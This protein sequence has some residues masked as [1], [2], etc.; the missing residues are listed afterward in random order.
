MIVVCD[1]ETDKLE[2]PDR[3][4]CIV[5]R[6]V[7]TGD[8]IVFV[9]PDKNPKAFLEFTKGVT[10]WVGHNFIAFDGP[11]INKL[12]DAEI[13]LKDS[14]ID[15]LVVSRLLNYSLD[16]HSLADWGHRFGFKKDNFS[17]F[18]Q[19]SPELRDR[20]IQDTKINL[21]LY[22]KFLPYFS[23]TFS[24][25]IKTEHSIAYYCGV[26]QQNGFWYNKKQADTYEAELT[27]I[28]SKAESALRTVFPLRSK[29]IKE[30]T[31]R[32]T[33]KGTLSI[34]NLKYLRSSDGTLD[35]TPYVAGAPFS[36][37]IWKEFNPSS[38]KDRLDRLWEARWKPYEKTK[39]HILEAKKR[40]PDKKKLAEYSVY[41]WKTS[42]GNLG[43]LPKDAPE[44][45]RTLVQWL[46]LSSRY[47]TLGTWRKAF[48]EQTGRIHGTFHS[49]GAWT[50]RLSHSNP[51]M[52]NIPSEYRRDSTV[53]PYGK[54]F[55]SLW[56]VP[57]GKLQVGTDAAGIQ[58]RVFAHYVNDPVFIKA[59]VSGSKDT[60]DDIHSLNM[61]IL[62]SACQ[63]RATAK[64]FVYAWILGAGTK[65]IA[66]ILGCSVPEAEAALARMQKA[67]PG[68]DIL[69][70]EIIP[71]DAQ[72]GYF[73]GFDG[74]IV[75]V[76][77]P[78]LIPTGYLQNGEACIMKRAAEIWNERLQKDRIPYLWIDFVHDEFQTEVDNNLDLCHNIGRV[79]AQAIVQAGE[80]FS[81]NCPQDGEYKVGRN[82]FETHSDDPDLPLA[83]GTSK[84]KIR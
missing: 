82:W 45:S 32:N 42:E 59:I 30:I 33:S 23:S 74:R 68:Y 11:I 83:R 50:H 9:E 48:L 69:Q 77:E 39:G 4:W 71:R 24:S 44:A 35:L 21:E 76:P 6:P 10:K 46:L 78:R 18:S 49:I 60:G 8:P 70:K 38:K 81:L 55:R 28:L 1:I 56:G 2:S 40:H 31:P 64:N 52:A 14:V 66:E 17:D 63:S 54:E 12:L 25:A 58:L 7:E 73:K 43:T 16:G 61:R 65:K 36:R 34:V 53:S 67:I 29:K 27:L 26:L 15:T 22:N 75:L 41:G 84:G 20:C 79:Q 51:N 80:E 57:E 47:R 13:N 5:C 37:F 62:G 19:Y 72:N 3:I